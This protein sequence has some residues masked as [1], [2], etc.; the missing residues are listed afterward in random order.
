MVNMADSI[1]K[2]I[3]FQLLYY[4]WEGNDDESYSAWMVPQL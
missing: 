3:T 2:D 1:L 4:L